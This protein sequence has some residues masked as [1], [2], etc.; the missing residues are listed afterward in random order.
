MASDDETKTRSA[1]NRLAQRIHK[2]GQQSG[3]VISFDDARGRARE[4]AVQYKR[5]KQD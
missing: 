1:I 4:V 3:R 5:K 2:D